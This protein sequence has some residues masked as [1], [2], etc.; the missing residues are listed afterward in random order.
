VAV[1][2]VNPQP[3]KERS[4]V[5]PIHGLVILKPV[6]NNTTKA[7]PHY[8]FPFTRFVL[9]TMSSL[10]RHHRHKHPLNEDGN[11]FFVDPQLN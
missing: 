3:G 7:P 1:A 9:R 4:N 2:T 8:Y 6:Y 10:R 11:P 5:D